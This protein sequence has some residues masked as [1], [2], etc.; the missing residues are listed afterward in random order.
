MSLIINYVV[1]II[2]LFAV[3]SFLFVGFQLAKIW[4]FTLIVQ[5]LFDN[6]GKIALRS[7]R[8]VTLSPLQGQKR[9]KRLFQTSSLRRYVETLTSD[10]VGFSYFSERVIAEPHIVNKKLSPT[11]FLCPYAKK[12]N[13]INQRINT[14][15][16]GTWAE[17]KK[18]RK[19]NEKHKLW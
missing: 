8:E 2:V 6:S 12:I 4:I 5:I 15:A 7:S 19:K 17:I 11:T 14:V 1:M 16:L 13:Q 10:I 18:N 9:K 3:C